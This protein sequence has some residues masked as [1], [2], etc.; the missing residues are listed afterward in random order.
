LVKK[1]D[2]IGGGSTVGVGGIPVAVG[3]FVPDVAGSEPG[4][5]RETVFSSDAKGG[6]LSAGMDNPWQAK[7]SNP[8][9]VIIARKYFFSMFPFLVQGFVKKRGISGIIYLFYHSRQIRP[10]T[11]F[12]PLDEPPKEVNISTHPSS[13]CIKEMQ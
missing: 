1:L 9:A 4:V 11:I 8:D 5:E 3:A 6:V 13:V 10:K 2:T 12:L 7:R